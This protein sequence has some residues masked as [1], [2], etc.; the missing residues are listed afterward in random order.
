MKKF[1]FSKLL[2]AVMLVA[3]L[4]MLSGCKP[5]ED[6]TGK[7]KVELPEAIKGTWK[8]ATSGD[9][10]I[11]SNDKILNTFSDV[12]NA[13]WSLNNVEIVKLDGTTK[14]T[15][16]LY[17]QSPETYTYS[18]TYE[19]QTYEGTYYNKD[20]YTAIYIEVVSETAIK[21]SCAA[22]NSSSAE[23]KDLDKVKKYSDTDG[24][25]TLKPEYEKQ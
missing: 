6:E 7:T 13:A 14:D 17:C 22:K 8:N 5:A 4:S 25:F 19:G 3:S 1:N 10:Y 23:D 15:Y 24:Y 18:M 20:Y 11:I 12:E 9:S 16:I 2:V 21:I